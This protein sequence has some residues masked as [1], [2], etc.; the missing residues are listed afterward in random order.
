[1][2][3]RQVR[4]GA[5]A[6]PGATCGRRYEAPT[7]SP[8]G[9][10]DVAREHVEPVA[11]VRCGGRRPRDLA[12]R[13]SGKRLYAANEHSGDV[14]WLDVDLATGIPHRAGSPPVPAASGIVF[15]RRALT[16]PPVTPCCGRRRPGSGHGATAPG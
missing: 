15:A 7:P 4:H 3:E 13:P 11:S 2:A 16:R 12:L 1:M 8:S 10:L 14:T 5:E 9:T 6:H